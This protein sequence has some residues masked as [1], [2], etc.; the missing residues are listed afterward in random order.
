M[1]A[2]EGG[3]GWEY[4]MFNIT[5]MLA[6]L[7]EPLYTCNQAYFQVVINAFALY[8]STV[9]VW[10][11][12]YLLADILTINTGQIIDNV[13]DLVDECFDPACMGLL[14]GNTF[15]LLSNKKDEW[16]EEQDPLINN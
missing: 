4:V 15:W 9:T 16:W 3:L 7:N 5:Y 10:S 8:N 2:Y 1:D 6:G 13:L 14:L 12:R 11:D